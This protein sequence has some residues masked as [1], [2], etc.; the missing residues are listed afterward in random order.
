MTDRMRTYGWPA[1]TLAVA[2]GVALAACTVGPDYVRPAVDAPTAWRIDYPKA[3]E[4]AN[5]PWWKQFGDPV[6]DD[7][8]DTALR[9][10]RDIRIA[11]A[12]VDQFIGGL[13]STRSQLYPQIG[14]GADAT[15]TRQ[16]R[17]GPTPI[18]P[19]RSARTS[20]STRARSPRNG[21]STSSAACSA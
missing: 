3:A 7:L 8:I 17:V 2:A 19:S 5:T 16:S 4:V 13:Q 10:N 21:R 18:P 9:E 1:R 6:L 11:A 12:R 20:R 14:Y 15:R